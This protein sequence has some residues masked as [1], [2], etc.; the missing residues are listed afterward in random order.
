MARNREA[1]E[2][3]K[4]KI[5]D[6]ASELFACHGVSGTGIRDIAAKAG[7]THALII[8]YFG[9]KDGLVTAIL[10]REISSLA[11][12]Y[13]AKPERSKAEALEMLRG[14]LLNSL[15]AQKRTM[16]LILRAGLDELS[17]ESYVEPNTER[18]ASILAKWIAS[19]QAGESLPDAK[20]V[21]LVVMSTLFSLTAIAPWLLTSV[22]LPPTDLDNRKEDIVDVLI[23]LMIQAVG[24][25]PAVCKPAPDTE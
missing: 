15:E 5:M 13:P 3:S 22:G 17:P 7:V 25:P 19:H 4:Q 1:S 23:W 2:S 11:S 8:R 24:S 16:R 6:A 20:L 18:V 10:R 14:V 9:S 21:S 12:P